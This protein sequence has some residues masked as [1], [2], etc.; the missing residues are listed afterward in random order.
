MME[1]EGLRIS[2]IV[3]V[4]NRAEF[5]PQLIHALL[6]Q[7]YRSEIII[8]DDGSTD[9]TAEI[10]KGYPVKYVYQ[11]NKGPASARNHGARESKGDIL[12]F[13]D[14]DCIP[15]ENWIEKLIRGF[16]E[17]NIGAVA[18]S[19]S[20]T[21]PESILATCI[22]EEIKLRHERLKMKKYV[23]AFG[24]YNV[25][26]RRDVFFN[27]GGFN[28]EYRFASGE[29]NDLSYK[30][31]KS[32]YKILFK[33]DALV[34]HNHTEKLWRYLKEQY[35]HGVWRIKMYRDFPEMVRG[36]DY[37]TWKD[38][39][40]IP[41]VIGSFFSFVFVWSLYGLLSFGIFITLNF[42]LQM[43]TSFILIIKKKNLKF[44]YLS[45]IMFLRSYARAVGA[46]SGILRFSQRYT[47]QAKERMR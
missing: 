45:V 25:A 40:E 3:P 27:V 8:V 31:L 33:D 6:K 2:V 7:T 22:H 20:I 30:I 24:S 9:N 13:T 10:A 37:T 11:E 41:L 17:D 21:N 39:A 42:L 18:G 26:I 19:Y 23:R 47:Y 32:G 1:N 16:S 4:Y 35:R 14:S 34:A 15:Y 46:V 43:K 36:D 29:D 44:I 5:I 38:I 12:V 28:E